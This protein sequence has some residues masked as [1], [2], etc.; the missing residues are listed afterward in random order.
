[1]RHLTEDLHRQIQKEIVED[2]LVLGHPVFILWVVY[3]RQKL[4]RRLNI[5]VEELRQPGPLDRLED[6]GLPLLEVGASQLL[7]RQTEAE[8]GNNRQRGG[9]SHGE[10]HGRLIWL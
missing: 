6:L 2:L 4:W 9:G 5:G 3:S 8:R 10:A 1:M 7:A